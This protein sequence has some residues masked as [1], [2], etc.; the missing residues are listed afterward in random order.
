MKA[1][2]V[3]FSKK[4]RAFDAPVSYVYTNIERKTYHKTK[5]PSF[6]FP[7]YS[8]KGPISGKDFLNKFKEDEKKL[9][10]ELK[11]ITPCEKEDSTNDRKEVNWRLHE[12][13]NVHTDYDFGFPY[14]SPIATPLMFSLYFCKDNNINTIII[15]GLDYQALSEDNKSILLRF[16]HY[17]DKNKISFIGVNSKPTRIPL[18]LNLNKK[19]ADKAISKC[20]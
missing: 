10:H 3:S 15:E 2:V 20:I 16:L 19:D 9:K 17:G 18:I 8:D 5:K 12:N 6:I 14:I 13:N 4:S 7:I 11:I 1:S